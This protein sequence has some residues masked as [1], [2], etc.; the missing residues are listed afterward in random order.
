MNHL[1]SLTFRIITIQSSPDK[2]EKEDEEAATLTREESASGL[3]IGSATDSGV[4]L[5]IL[6]GH[7]A[8][9]LWDQDLG[10]RNIAMQSDAMMEEI[11][12]V[13]PFWTGPCARL[14]SWS[15]GL[16]T[17]QLLKRTV[18]CPTYI[19][20]TFNRNDH[21]KWQSFLVKNWS[22]LKRIQNNNFWHSSFFSPYHEDATNISL[23]V[24]RLV[25]EANSNSAWC[26]TFWLPF[27]FFGHRGKNTFLVSHHLTAERAYLP[28][29]IVN[30]HSRVIIPFIIMIEIL[31][32]LM[33]P[34]ICFWYRQFFYVTEWRSKTSIW[35]KWSFSAYTLPYRQCLY[36]ASVSG[37][38]YI[39]GW[40]PNF[41]LL[42]SFAYSVSRDIFI[43]FNLHHM[44]CY[45]WD[46]TCHVSCE[47]W[48]LWH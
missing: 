27:N 26:H 7:E 46:V 1:T 10:A 41:Q 33:R 2:P 47:N 4:N 21:C 14:P 15:G 30:W 12:Q 25:F 31:S 43:L 22:D 24:P 3:A 48:K 18:P 45:L 13:I 38:A 40:F 37:S 29:V 39:P 32:K 28:I 20:E 42:P 11:I 16:F 17:F 9:Q 8:M 5:Y 23:C 35:L 44:P 34:M 6:A 36:S 19:L